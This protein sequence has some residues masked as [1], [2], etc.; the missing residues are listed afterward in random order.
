[1][2]NR[3]TSDDMMDLVHKALDA[4]SMQH[5]ALS[6][7]IAN[8]DTPG[9]KRS[10]VVFS[11]KLSAAMDAKHAPSDDLERDRTDDRHFAVNPSQDLSSITPEL[12]QQNMTSFR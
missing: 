10:E 6:N 2:I 9:F 8:V 1:M 12:V 11:E 4:S 7:N 5:M 3:L